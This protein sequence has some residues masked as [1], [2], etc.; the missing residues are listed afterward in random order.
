MRHDQSGG[1]IVRKH[2]AGEDLNDTDL[3]VSNIVPH[4]P[5]PMAITG[6]FKE[7]KDTSWLRIPVPTNFIN[8]LWTTDSIPPQRMPASSQRV[9]RHYALWADYSGHPCLLGEWLVDGHSGREWLAE[10]APLFKYLSIQLHLWD[11]STFQLLKDTPWLDKLIKNGGRN[12]DQN[13]KS[14]AVPMPDK[15]DGTRSKLQT[16]LTQLRLKAA[17][18]PNDQSKLRLALNCLTGEAMNQVQAYVED[19]RVNLENL[20]AL[21][22]ILDTA[23]GNPNRIAEA[24]SKLSTIQQGAR[25]FLPSRG[26]SPTKSLCSMFQ[27]SFMNFTHWVFTDRLLSADPISELTHMLLYRQ[28]AMQLATNQSTW[29]LFIPIYLG[30]STKDFD[31]SRLGGML[32]QVKN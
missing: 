7:S 24:E 3:P 1:N 12:L 15:F 25:E 9:H 22:M 32:I 20:A 4:N 16:F 29:D 18:Y 2:D 26:P 28:A 31:V 5:L 19:D 11:P 8:M 14:G 6:Q 23:F 17:S 21:I 30:D 13:G 10:N 27:N